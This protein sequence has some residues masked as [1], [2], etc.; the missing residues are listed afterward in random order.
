MTETPPKQSERTL[1]VGLFVTCPVDLIRPSIGFATASLLEQA[2]C[3]VHAP[4]QSCCGQVAFN[5]GQPEET[6]ALAWNIVEQFG[7]YDYVVIPS[8]SC[9]GTIK[10][11]YPELFNKQDERHRAVVEFCEKVYELT[12]FLTQVL[13]YSPAQAGV[14]LSSQTVT[15]HDSCAGLR[16][17]GI[18]QQPRTLLKRC[19]NLDVTEMQE[20]DVCCGFGGTFCVKYSDVSNRMV[21][22]KVNNIRQSGA[23]MVL[24]GDLSCL[25]NIAG[26]LQRL[27]PDNP[28]RVQVRHI[29]EVLAGELNTP[30]I[31]E[32]SSPVEKGE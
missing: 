28:N 19:A 3:D 11:H 14:D 12:T 13:D 31:G 32:S 2:G 4:P 17:L 7:E 16:E 6:R 15:Y 27:E 26:K 8:G 22:N 20:T 25:L 18:K 21:G 5:N 30:A 24:G 9:G 23:S 10:T 1:Q 29:A